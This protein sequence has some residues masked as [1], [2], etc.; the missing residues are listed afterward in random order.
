M[1]ASILVV[2]DEE[3]ILTSLSSILRDEGY[4]VAVVKNGLEALRVYT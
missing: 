1:S 3:S 2:D 4:D